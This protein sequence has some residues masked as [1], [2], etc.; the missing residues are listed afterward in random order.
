MGRTTIAQQLGTQTGLSFPLTDA[1]E[2]LGGIHD[3]A[4]TTARDAIPA[5][6]LRV[7]MLA[8]TLADLKLWVLTDDSPVTWAEVDLGGAVD[9]SELT[10]TATLAQLP[11][12]TG[13]L[14]GS[15][16]APSY[17]STVA[18][19]H[20]ANSGGSAGDLAT[21]TGSVWQRLA[22]GSASQ[23]LKGGSAPVWGSVAFS[24]LTGSAT[25][26][27]FP[28]GTGYLKGSGST[29]T[30]TATVALA[31]LGGPT[32]GANGDLVYWTGSAYTRLAVGGANTVLKGG[33]SVPAYSALV[34]GD[35]P[36]IPATKLSDGVFGVG[37]QIETPAA[38]GATKG[39]QITKCLRVQTTNTTSTNAW[40][41]TPPASCTVR[42]YATFQARKS[43]DSDQ[44]G[45]DC[46]AS[47]KVSSGGTVTAGLTNAYSNEEP[48]SAAI[49]V[50]AGSC[51]LYVNG[52]TQIRASV[53]GTASTNWQ[54][55]VTITAV[56][57]S[58]AA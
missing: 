27:Q 22:V 35:I 46:I 2:N 7:G 3:V 10:G 32:S 45:V 51:G 8:F 6:V 39:N 54:W 11:S 18:L 36:S 34:V 14:Y 42:V 24:E 37:T 47:F 58:S 50:A 9:F 44:F 43:D 20:L 5:H 1:R 53:I 40:I 23:V 12:G 52:T 38:E 57:C 21:W 15:G 29:P 33:G 28:T 4:D 31:D 17:V 26:A 25:L 49:N 55:T 48:A 13:Y 30:Y 19:G 41:Y 16:G 56:I